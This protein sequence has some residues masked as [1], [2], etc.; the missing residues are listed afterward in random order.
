LIKRYQDLLDGIP[1]EN[2]ILYCGSGVTSIHS[3][4]AMVI[5][6]FDM[7][8]LFQGSW[9]EWTVDPDRPVGP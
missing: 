6:G 2:V 8:K 5:A 1:A 9:S 7:P 4:I 3:M